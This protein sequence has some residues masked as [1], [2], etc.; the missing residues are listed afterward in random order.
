MAVHKYNGHTRILGFLNPFSS[1]SSSPLWLS[2]SWYCRR[3]FLWSNLGESALS[4]ARI[5]II[6]TIIII[7][8]MIVIVII[9]MIMMKRSHLGEC[10][11]SHPRIFQVPT[12]VAPNPNISLWWWDESRKVFW[13]GPLVIS[14]LVIGP[15]VIGP[16]VIGP[17][18]I[19]S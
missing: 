2:S 14:P 1:S 10:A 4:Y 3:S 19:G 15:L 9:I 12:L 8:V 18:V 17:L 13:I 5:I 6:I 7:I 11:R 16:L